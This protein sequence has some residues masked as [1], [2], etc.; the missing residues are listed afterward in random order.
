MGDEGLF[1]IPHGSCDERAF[2]WAGA[3]GAQ[4]LRHRMQHTAQLVTVRATALVCCIQHSS[5]RCG[6]LLRYGLATNVLTL[7]RML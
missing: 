6:C 1:P 2:V 7:E 3:Q 4:N 5:V